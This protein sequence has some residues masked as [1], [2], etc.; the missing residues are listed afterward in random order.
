MGGCGAVSA[1]E[2]W[3]AGGLEGTANGPRTERAVRTASWPL[4]TAKVQPPRFVA[5]YH[6]RDDLLQR[7]EP[8]RRLT[9]LKAAGGFGK[10]TLLAD[11]C[12]RWR[13]AGRTAAW[14]SLD[15]QDTPGV[16]DAYLA[17][18]FEHAGLRVAGAEGAWMN[19]RGVELP[20]RVRRRTELLCVAIEAHAAPCLLLLDEVDVVRDPGAVDTLNF[21]LQ[22]AP[23]NLH[24]AMALRANPGLDLASAILSGDGIYLTADQLR[25]PKERI[26]LFFDSE[27]SRRELGAIT[28][29]TEGW[30]VALRVYRN[31][32]SES[33]KQETGVARL[34][35]DES[36]VAADWLGERLLRNLAAADR[37]ML[38]DLSLFEWIT[39]AFADEVLR[40]SDVRRRINGLVALDGLVQPGADADTLRLNPVLK[41]HCAN[42]RFR[43]DP[44]RFR[45]IH[46][47]IAEFEAK[48]RRWLPALR[49][50][51]E[52]GGG[53]LV[54]QIVE[55]AGGV[56]LWA[57]F[58]EKMLMSADACIT[59]SVVEKF[60]RAALVRCT[61]SALARRFAQAQ[62]LYMEIAARTAGFTRDRAGGDD[63]ALRDDNLLVQMTLVSFACL[64][65]SGSLMRQVV[66]AAE[67]R[68]R[69]PVADPVVDGALHMGLLAVDQQRGMLTRARERGARATK[70]FTEC[71]ASYGLV[72]NNLHLGKL[73]MA[74]GRTDEAVRLLAQGG[75]TTIADIY[76]MELE[77][78]RT[79]G[80]FNRQ[81]PPM[82]RL[83]GWFDVYAA[84]YGLAADLAFDKGDAQAALLVVDEAGEQALA[85]GQIAVQR[86]LAA[87]R[88]TWLVRDGLADQAEQAWQRGNLPTETAR[89]LNLEGQSWRE[90]EAI[91]CARVRFLAAAG[92]TAAGR[93]LITAFCRLCA[94]RGLY[95][96]LMTGL[97]VAIRVEVLAGDLEAAAAH[98]GR[99]LRLIR[100]AD[101]LRPLACER[102]VVRE[103]LA[104]FLEGQHS[105]AL[106]ERARSVRER[107]AEPDSG[108]TPTF[109]ERELA[110]VEGVESG[111]RNKE[112]ARRLGLSENGVRYHLKNIYRKTGARTRIDAARRVRNVG[113]G[114]W[115]WRSRERP[116]AADL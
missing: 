87:L 63:D 107:L 109:T 16:L 25:F 43:E 21:L 100:R 39:P 1:N 91:C 108:A 10:T 15:G 113:V 96:P 7:L 98:L 114:G 64:P 103:A 106:L 57:Q 59:P 75:S 35:G 4:L 24:I 13:E 56:R 69:R 27:L 53:D 115:A 104:V 26:A 111:L 19:D 49:H 41:D 83:L 80:G 36:R 73:A 86:F 82:R 94:D 11:V 92:N 33:A 8:L 34:L 88:V 110:I 47:R 81:L 65:L 9:V 90:M 42:Q 89:I 116:E 31:M 3:P 67:E 18:A 40:T 102:E 105:E 71:G 17:F 12:R 51:S 52:A 76:L 44:E 20:H 85:R 99:Y 93:E 62:T 79:L 55:R 74:Q 97:A 58:G 70:R 23:R 30:P 29:R 60:P 48:E 95:W 2:E 68:V 46:R 22:H 66:A 78:V 72:S 77:Y 50:A 84:A 14:L 112:I 54:G 6:R 5:G 101:L 32:R 61:A 38:L 28:Q 45:E 37:Q